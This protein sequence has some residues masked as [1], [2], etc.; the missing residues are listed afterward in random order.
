[1][2]KTFILGLGAQKSGTSWLFKY[3]ET[4]DEY[5]APAVKELHVWDAVEGLHARLLHPLTP[6]NASANALRLAMQYCH[7]FYFLYFRRLLSGRKTITSDI[8]PSY[9]ALPLSRLKTISNRFD[10][11]KIETKMIFCMRDPVDRIVSAFRMY[12]KLGFTHIAGVGDASE[13]TGLVQ[14]ARTIGCQRRT[15]YEITLENL[16]QLSEPAKSF[17]GTYEKIFLGKQFKPLYEF[18]GGA[19]RSE[20]ENIRVHAGPRGEIGA[21]IAAELAETYRE[22]YAYCAEHF[23]ETVEWWKFMPDHKMQ[24]NQE[25]LEL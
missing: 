19:S 14:F 23:P 20:L 2:R 13:S 16:R 22:T 1:M 4:L 21:E 3:L 18:I 11:V 17:V 10:R 9:A 7:S 5:A 25:G 8:S 12:R 24:T 6:R 15:R